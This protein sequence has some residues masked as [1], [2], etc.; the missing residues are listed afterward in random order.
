MSAERRAADLGFGQGFEDAEDPGD[1]EPIGKGRLVD[2]GDEQ[3]KAAVAAA[4]E[5]EKSG[6]SR[7]VQQAEAFQA[8]V[9]T[10]ATRAQASKIAEKVVQPRKQIPPD[11]GQMG[12]GKGR[13]GGKGGAKTVKG[14]AKRHRKLLRDN[15]QGITKP[16]LR[17]CARRAGVKRISGLIYEES[18]AN[19]A[20]YL[21]VILKDAVTFTEHAHRKT[22]V[23]MDVVYSL[24][25]HPEFGTVLYGF[26]YNA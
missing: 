4:K 17:R 10:G 20:R 14:G 12:G 5:A 26:G 8:A 13:K 3:V 22:V 11:F 6:E 19:I 9:E 15:I 23:A 18:R 7:P 2:V 1:V 25:R 24:K 16:A 21:N